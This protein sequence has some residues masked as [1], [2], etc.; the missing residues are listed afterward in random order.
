MLKVQSFVL[1]TVIQLEVAS[2]GLAKGQVWV[3]RAMPHHLILPE[4]L[5]QHFELGPQAYPRLKC[6][7]VLCF[8][9]LFRS[10]LRHRAKLNC[11]QEG[12]CHQQRVHEVTTHP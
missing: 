8:D 11:S 1:A 3:A 9:L 7:N 2:F 10:Y 5:S 6:W 12:L 4:L